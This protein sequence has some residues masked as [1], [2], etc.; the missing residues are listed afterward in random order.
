MSETIPVDLKC[1]SQRCNGSIEVPD[2][3]QIFDG[4]EGICHLCNRVYVATEFEDG[5]MSMVFDEPRTRIY[6][7]HL[8]KPR[9]R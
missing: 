7:S 5:S 1:T 4:A 8:R 6:R 9:T 3:S 2:N